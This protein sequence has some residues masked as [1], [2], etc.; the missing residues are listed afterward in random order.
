VPDLDLLERA[1]RLVAPPPSSAAPLLLVARGGRGAEVGE[2]GREEGR[3]FELALERADDIGGG[4]VYGL[5]D[6][7]GRG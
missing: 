1:A 7:W 6:C 3:G 2:V 5:V 4:E